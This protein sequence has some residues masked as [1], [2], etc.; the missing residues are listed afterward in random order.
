M[1]FELA[2]RGDLRSFLVHNRKTETAPS[3]LSL[4]DLIYM[5]LDVVKGMVYLH[6][7]NFVHRDL[8]ARNCLV[9]ADMTVKITDFGLSRQVTIADYY[10]KQGLKVLPIRWAAPEAIPVSYTHLTL[11]TIYSV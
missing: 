9:T 6:S 10:R 1:I 7:K 5:G 2:L 3:P 4:Q 8:A 11:P